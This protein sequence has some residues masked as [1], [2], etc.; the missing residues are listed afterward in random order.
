MVGAAP[1]GRGDHAGIRELL[2]AAQGYAVF[3]SDRKRVGVFIELTGAG[4]DQ[5][6]IRDDGV[7]LWRRRVLPI[8]AVAGVFPEQRAVVLDLDRRSLAGFP[9][10]RDAAAEPVQPTD[11]PREPSEEMQ[12]RLARY[13]S[14]LRAEID[15]ARHLAFVSSSNGYT[16]VELQGPPP[17]VGTN[18]DVAELPG[19]FVVAKLGASPLPNDARVCAYLEPAAPESAQIADSSR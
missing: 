7:F 4:A 8:T 19:S 14:P 3:G 10:A 1:P 11:P 9:P 17:S 5:I 18:V 15:E 16:L 2:A 12:E 13:L 6:A